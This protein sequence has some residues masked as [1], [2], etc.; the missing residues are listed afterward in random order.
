[1]Q[2]HLH[3]VQH[4]QNQVKILYLLFNVDQLHRNFSVVL[5]KFSIFVCFVYELMVLLLL[6]VFIFF[7]SFL[8]KYILWAALLLNVEGCF[9]KRDSSTCKF[10][11]FQICFSFNIG[12]WHFVF[13][14]RF[15]FAFCFVCAFFLQIYFHSVQLLLYCSLSK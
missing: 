13:L 4:S 5:I 12:L 3:T 7:F 1:M 15:L 2:L 10:I 11:A 8:Y 6:V 9:C 14:F